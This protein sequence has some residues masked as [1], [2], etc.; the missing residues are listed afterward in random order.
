M[1][2]RGPS[3]TVPFAVPARFLGTGMIALV[4]AFTVLAFRPELLLTSYAAPSVL[5]LVHVLTLGFATMVLVG[6][7]HPLM[8]VLLVAE[9][10][11]P[12]LGTATFVL[13]LAGVVGVVLGFATG[14]RLAPLVIGGCLVIAA[15][16]LF[17]L[18]LWWT[19]R[20]S[21]GLD[22][23][24]RTMLASA[25]Y[26]SATALLGLTIALS[27][28]V[29][30]LAG[31][32][33]HA[34]PLHLGLGLFGAFFLA[35]AAAGHKLLGMF[36]LAHGASQGRL[37]LIARL[38]HAGVLLLAAGTFLGLRVNAATSVLL[39]CAVALFFVDVAVLFRKRMRRRVDAALWPYLAA[40]L[41]LVSAVAFAAAGVM[42]AAVA[43]LLLG[44]LP[45]AVAGMIIKIASFLTWQQRYAPRV[46]RGP[47]P[48]LGDMHVVPLGCATASGFASGALALPAAVAWSSPELASVGAVAAAMGAWALLFHLAWIMLGRHVPRSAGARA[49]VSGG[50]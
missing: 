2:S 33:G 42:P 23:V 1:T 20:A 21:A 12:R 4:T 32:L 49:A 37:R 34:T 17:D 7:M 46:G 8:P 41:P 50:G 29:P 48:M 28:A 43:A 40:P 31:V 6:A 14:Y 36:V 38:V 35:V 44:F 24:A 25:G 30:G 45:L 22:V 3:T 5:A 26:L 9:L 11:S 16:L 39:T 47:V 27:R 19:A 18:N 15:L 10:H 13:L